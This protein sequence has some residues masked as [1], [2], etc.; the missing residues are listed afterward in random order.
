MTAR[1][2]SLHAELV[3]IARRLSR[4]LRGVKPGSAVA[5]TYDP[6]DYA[7]RAHAAFLSLARARPR[8][9]LV[10]MNPG[11][12]GM[13]QTGVPFG[14]VEAVREFLGIDSGV[15]SPRRMHPRRPVL[16]FECPRSEVSGRR[17]W[18]LMR[19]AF[20]T[21]CRFFRAAFVWN[22]CPLAFTAESG[23]N[24]TPDHLPSPARRRIELACD[25]AL[26]DVIK[27]LEPRMVIG[28]G[29]FARDAAQRAVADRIPVHVV[30]HPSPASP[31]ANRGWESRA[32][33]QLRAC[34]FLRGPT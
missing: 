19:Q 16:G 14:E 32:R 34:G 11:P 30:L 18:G 28:V 4:D 13:V 24:I 9:L 2:S 12:F 15:R 20:G 10:G 7:W 33:R 27:A 26:R 31:A 17:F 8:A 6:L 5:C 23:A 22:W 1:S 3:R 29:A 21:R 25:A